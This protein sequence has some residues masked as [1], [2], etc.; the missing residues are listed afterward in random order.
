MPSSARIAIV[1]LLFFSA[2]VFGEEFEIS[3]EKYGF[4]T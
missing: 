3:F 4:D 2:S 1:S